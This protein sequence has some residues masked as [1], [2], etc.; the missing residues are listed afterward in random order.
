MLDID[1]TVRTLESCSN[2]LTAIQTMVRMGR[3]AQ[4]AWEVLDGVI[5]DLDAITNAAALEPSDPSTGVYVEYPGN[6]SAVL[7]VEDAERLISLLQDRLSRIEDVLKQVLY[8][9]GSHHKQWGLSQ[10][11]V[12]FGILDGEPGIVP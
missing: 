9:D 11:A 1:E 4:V 2:R 7:T 8:V 5:E 3:T 12:E 10:I 6:V